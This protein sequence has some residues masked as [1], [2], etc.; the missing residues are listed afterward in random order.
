MK[1]LVLA[2][3]RGARIESVTQGVPTCLLEF[4]DRTIFDCQIEA[5]WAAGTS[6][7]GIVTGHNRQCIHNH[8]N[9]TYL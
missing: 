6:E 1:A 8:L 7:I 5:L 2:A 4:G 3:G 9:R